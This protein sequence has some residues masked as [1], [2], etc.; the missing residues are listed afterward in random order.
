MYMHPFMEKIQPFLPPELYEEAE[1]TKFI[2]KQ[3]IFLH[4]K[5]H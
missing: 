1:E 4:G 5:T 3:K 2:D